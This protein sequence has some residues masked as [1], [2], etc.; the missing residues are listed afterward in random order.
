MHAIVRMS[1]QYR[2]FMSMIKLIE[3]STIIRPPKD[4]HQKGVL[5]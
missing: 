1:L 5:I 4:N 3:G 2:H